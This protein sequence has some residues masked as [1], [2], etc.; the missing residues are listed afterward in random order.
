MYVVNLHCD[1]TDRFNLEHLHTLYVGVKPGSDMN[2]VQTGEV[3]PV[4]ALVLPVDWPRVRG[5]DVRN[6]LPQLSWGSEPLASRDVDVVEVG[7]CS[8]GEYH[9]E[10]VWWISHP[11]RTS[12]T[13]SDTVTGAGTGAWTGMRRLGAVVVRYVGLDIQDRR[14]VHHVDPSEVERVP[15]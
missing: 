11:G 9:S 15:L 12:D 7:F 4:A 10:I 14:P 1:I 13:R 5:E 2:P 8:A 6:G 3:H